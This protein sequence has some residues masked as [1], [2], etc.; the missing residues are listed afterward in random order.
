MTNYSDRFLG[1]FQA[2]DATHAGVV[3]TTT[4]TLAGA[5]TFNGGVVLGTTPTIGN[6]GGG[7]TITLGS[8]N[9]FQPTV[10]GGMDLGST[11]SRWSDTYI[12]DGK[13]IDFSSG[14]TAT[15]VFDGS[16]NAIRPSITSGLDFGATSFRWSTIYA[17]NALNTSDAN[18]K[19]NIYDSDLGL[20]FIKSLRPVSYSWKKDLNETD[21]K[22]HYGFIAQE[23]EELVGTNDRF[24]QKS[25]G[26][27]NLAYNDL[28]APMVKAIQEQQ[29]MIEDLKG[30]KVQLLDRLATLEA[31]LT[32]ANL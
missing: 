10:N 19:E 25:E 18:L 20:D 7:G 16:N 28:I 14:S 31:R 1:P 17:A 5:K 26:T 12:Y 15:L 6:S 11:G 32:S 13:K 29:E 27:Y 24:V 22:R 23:V 3:S 4:Q 2:A 8:S 30:E 21:L 9:N